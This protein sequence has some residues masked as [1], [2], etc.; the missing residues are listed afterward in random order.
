MAKYYGDKKSKMAPKS[1]G[2]ANM[3]S[4]LVMKEYPKAEY[5]G[6]EDYNDSREGIDML[7]KSNHKQMMKKRGGRY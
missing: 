1:K 6:P 3:P 5:G 4:E 2:H 7:A